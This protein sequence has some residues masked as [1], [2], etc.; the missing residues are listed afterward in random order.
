MKATKRRT[1]VKMSRS[2]SR[3]TVLRITEGE[4]ARLSA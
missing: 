1:N 4:V 3:M 2:F